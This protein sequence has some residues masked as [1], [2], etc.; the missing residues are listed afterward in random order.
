MEFEIF[1]LSNGIR[2]VHRQ[3]DRPVAH[4][5]LI[6]QAGS[7]DEKENEEGLAHFIE[8]V[9]F[10]G[11]T[12]RKAYHILSRMEDAGGELNAYTDKEN[13]VIYSSFLKADYSRAID[14]IFDIASNS[15]FPEK[16]LAKEK[17]VIIDEINSYKDSPSDLIFDEFEEILFPNHPLGTNILGTPERVKSFSRKNVLNFMQREYSADRMVFS[18]VGNI[19]GAR[20]KKILEKATDHNLAQAQPLQRS[21]PDA[22]QAVKRE[23]EKSNFQT[24]AVIGNRAYAADHKSSR[25]LHLLNNILGGPGMN[26]RLNLN[27][28]ERYGFTYNIESFYS[29]YSDTGV[30]GIYAGTDPDTIGKTLKLISKEM[31][32]LREKP[33]GSMQLTKAKRQILGQIAM[34][35]E[36]NAALMLALGRSLLTFGRIDTFEEIEKK[37]AG[38]TATEIMEVANEIMNQDHMSTLIYKPTGEEM[39]LEGQ[40]SIKY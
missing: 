14:L 21:Q 18:S 30:F 16:E 8:H 19:T 34:G 28:R 4:C 33:M 32:K 12:K 15:T 10:K 3:T 31:K 35:Q 23:K 17:E 40:S 20:L 25:T 29:P 6:I 2:V 13:T 24:H 9:L 26:S 11:T 36:N 7:R 1:E 22:Y 5:G 38:I 37:I 27:I 39:P